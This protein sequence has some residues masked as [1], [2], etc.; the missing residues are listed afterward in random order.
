VIR[1]VGNY[2]VTID[3]GYD[4]L[5]VVKLNVLAIKGSSEMAAFGAVD[6]AE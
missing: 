5:A 3:L 4:V 6:T 2:E 1:E